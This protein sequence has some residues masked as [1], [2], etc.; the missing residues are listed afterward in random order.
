LEILLAVLV[1]EVG[2]VLL[3]QEQYLLVEKTRIIILNM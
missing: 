1:V 2:D 3:L